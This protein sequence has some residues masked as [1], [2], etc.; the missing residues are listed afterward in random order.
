MSLC[1]SANKQTACI[2]VVNIIA[3]T[4]CYARDILPSLTDYTLND[5]E[6]VTD[7]YDWPVRWAVSYTTF[8]LAYWDRCNCRA[9]VRQLW[10]LHHHVHQ[11]SELH[12]SYRAADFLIPLSRNHPHRPLYCLSTTKPALATSLQIAGNTRT[13]ASG[14][15]NDDQRRR[16][17][18][19]VQR[20]DLLK[21]LSLVSLLKRLGF[22][23]HWF[24]GLILDLSQVTDI[25]CF[26]S[27][28]SC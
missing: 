9:S 19:K 17:T 27:H 1:F 15:Q 26:C 8:S 12:N 13:W 24:V 3:L 20:W 16:K 18:I 23:H 21:I 7:E 5:A 11:A 2:A 14:T 10:L 6:S 28:C 4:S 25:L 22:R